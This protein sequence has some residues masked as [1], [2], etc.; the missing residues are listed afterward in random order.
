MSRVSATL[1][2]CLACWSLPAVS[3][4]LTREEQAWLAANPELSLGTDHNWPPYEFSDDSEHYQ[5]L[6]ADYIALF[7]QRLPLKLRPTTTRNWSEVL[8]AAK[9]GQVNLLPSLMATPERRQ[10]LSFTRPYLDFPIVILTQDQGPQ[11]RNVSELQGMRV[12][13]VDSYATHELLRDK[14]PELNL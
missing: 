3:L 8:A 7:E 14:H 5:G 12:A 10:Y 9:A 13:V 2:L 11:P 6:A 1:L 4:E